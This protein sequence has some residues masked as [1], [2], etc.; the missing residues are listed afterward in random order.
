M[1]NQTTHP[2]TPAQP[3]LRKTTTGKNLANSPSAAVTR[4]G[5][6]STMATTA[7]TRTVLAERKELA[8]SKRPLPNG[9]RK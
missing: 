1:T 2:Q 3:E 5:A 4:R 8:V 6:C 7:T 9:E